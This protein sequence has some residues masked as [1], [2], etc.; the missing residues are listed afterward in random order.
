M[1]ITREKFR[2]LQLWRTSRYLMSFF[3]TKIESAVQ[4]FAGQFST[5]T[6]KPLADK[7]S[8]YVLQLQAIEIF[9]LLTNQLLAYGS[10]NAQ[11]VSLLIFWQG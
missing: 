5:A 1:N 4:E 2:E 9:D 6:L 11:G 8:R 7:R 10:A 3:N